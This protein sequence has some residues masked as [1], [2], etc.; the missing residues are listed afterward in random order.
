MAT[1][2]Q[3]IGRNVRAAREHRGLTAE[4]FAKQV[5]E[6]LGGSPWPRQTVYLL[7]VGG[8]RLAAEEVVAI[9]LVLNISIADLFTPQGDVERLEVGQQS[10]PRERLLTMGERDPSVYEV[11]HQ[12]QILRRSF[13]DLAAFMNAQRIVLENIDNALLGKPVIYE[14]PAPDRKPG[15]Q[16]QFDLSQDY[17]RVRQWHEETAHTRRLTASGDD[18]D[19]E[20][21]LA[22]RNG[23]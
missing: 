3:V 17:Q 2:A 23:Q 21:T 12:T 5:G 6:I 10:V 15:L 11:A 1:P 14:Q 8:R 22:D 16:V 18:L 7:E 20:G 9:A 13:S 4:A 19:P